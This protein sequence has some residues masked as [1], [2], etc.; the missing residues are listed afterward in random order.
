M[1]GDV[2]GGGAS[3]VGGAVF[4]FFPWKGTCILVHG[5]V[6]FCNQARNLLLVNLDTL[7]LAR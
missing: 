6:V 2:L 1:G 5:I 4:C 3:F 7:Q